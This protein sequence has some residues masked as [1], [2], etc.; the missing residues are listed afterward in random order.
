MTS[1]VSRLQ[2]WMLCLLR[3]SHWWERPAWFILG[4]RYQKLKDWGW[5]FY[6]WLARRSGR[7]GDRR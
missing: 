5:Q 4:R 7:R 1:E 2:R 6:L 3:H